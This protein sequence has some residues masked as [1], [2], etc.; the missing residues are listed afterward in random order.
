MCYLKIKSRIRGYALIAQLV[1]HLFCKQKVAGSI[2]AEGIQALVA[3]LAERVAVNHKVFGSNP[4]R[5]DFFMLMLFFSF[6]VHL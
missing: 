4:N 6:F 5:S 3:Q 2:P 1:E